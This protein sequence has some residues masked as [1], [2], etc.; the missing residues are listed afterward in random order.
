MIDSKGISEYPVSPFLFQNHLPKK[1]NVIRVQG[2]EGVKKMVQ[3]GP[4]DKGPKGKGVEGVK[5]ASRVR[6]AHKLMNADCGMWNKI[7]KAV[8]R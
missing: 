2:A 5:R 8:N 1:D 3:R 4:G 6:G 7:G